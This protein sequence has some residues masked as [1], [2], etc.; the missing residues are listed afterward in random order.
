[1]RRFQ[2]GI[3]RAK[4]LLREGRTARSGGRLKAA[5]GFY[6]QA[7]SEFSKASTL[8][9]EHRAV[10]SLLTTFTRAIRRRDASGVD[11]VTVAH[12]VRAS[13]GTIRI[14]RARSGHASSQSPQP[15]HDSASNIGPYCS[16]SSLT[17]RP[18]NG[19]T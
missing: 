1:M 14:A 6:K 15:T 8:T 13:G 18:E 2:S 7:A 11:V 3:E 12:V 9:S 4:A 19:Q 17:A 5:L 16:P 10:R